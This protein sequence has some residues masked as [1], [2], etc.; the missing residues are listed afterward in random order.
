MKT[1]HKSMKCCY[2]SSSVDKVDKINVL[3]VLK[4]PCLILFNG[5]LN[6]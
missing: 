1:L 6:L 2:H 5:E 3:D 4:L